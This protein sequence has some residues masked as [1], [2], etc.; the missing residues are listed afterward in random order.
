[1]LVRSNVSSPIVILVLAEFV[2]IAFEVNAV[3]LPLFTITFP[4]KIPPSPYI[5]PRSTTIEF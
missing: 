2:D 1:M 4:A 5:S 3:I